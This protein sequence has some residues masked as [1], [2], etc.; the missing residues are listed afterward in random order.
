M[1]PL[2]S[3]ATSA[4]SVSSWRSTTR[5]GRVWTTSAV[6]RLPE[7]PLER[8]HRHQAAA[9]QRHA[10]HVHRGGGHP[11]DVPLRPHLAHGLGPHREPAA[12]DAQEQQGQQG[13]GFAAPRPVPLRAGSA[14][15]PGPTAGPGD[16]WR[17]P[18]V[19]RWP[20]RGRPFRSTL[21]SCRPCRALCSASVEGDFNERGPRPSG[22]GRS[23][24]ADI[25]AKAPA[26]RRGSNV[27]LAMGRC[28]RC[29]GTA[30]AGNGG[31]WPG[32]RSSK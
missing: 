12:A 28:R 2:V 20:S 29:G 9:D 27:I 31:R 24:P 32:P 3:S 1:T 18:R 4:I 22:N 25:V 21:P 26:R 30:F 19:P 15:L 6:P 10:Q 8:Q 13:R 7:Q 23:G 16:G 17:M 11:G 5:R 14:R